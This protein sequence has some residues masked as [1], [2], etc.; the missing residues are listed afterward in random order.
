MIKRIITRIAPSPTGIAHLGSFRT[1]LFNYLFAKQHNGKF[2]LRIE[3]TDQERFVPEAE[4]YIIESLNWLGIVPDEGVNADGTATY[5]QSERKEIYKQHLQVLLDN[6]SAYYAFDTPAELEKMRMDFGNPKTK[7]AK[8]DSVTRQYMK[9]SL[10]LSEAEVKELVATG[11]YVV[12]FRNE[13]NQL[14][15]FKD[16]I[17]GEIT[18]NT[19]DLD[20]KV[21][22]KGKQ[23]LPTYHL[24]NVVDDHLMEV[25]HV[26]RGEEWISSTPLHILLYNAFGWDFPDFYHLPLILRP[27]GNGKLSKRDGDLMGF[28]VHPLGYRQ[29]GFEPQA[30]VNFLA[31]LGWNPGTEQEIYSMDE[32]VRDFDIHRVQR[33]GAKFDYEKA[34]WFNQKHVAKGVNLEQLKD[35]EGNNLYPKYSKEYIEQVFNLVKDRMTFASDFWKFSCYFFMSNPLF[36]LL[37]NIDENGNPI[38]ESKMKWLEKFNPK[39]RAFFNDYSIAI[40]ETEDFTAE[41]LHK[42]AVGIC[43]FLKIK[44]SDVFPLFRIALSGGVPGASVF[45]IQAVLGKEAS[46]SRIREFNN[47][48]S[49]LP[50]S[51]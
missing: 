24:A 28:P 50:I 45:D 35:N 17:R 20:D 6:G 32:L 26:I 44:T 2:L 13:I 3:D 21:I 49:F 40:Q 19:S 8:Y 48:T 22:F 14:V 12:R 36:M 30:V 39:A 37:E 10:T 5:R 7:D 11:D 38:D 31:F 43:E 9:N 29:Q 47:S 34:K 4:K 46:I 33:A 42:I 16:Q 1:A 15:T 51:V 25:T 23:Q 41:N 27:K 18:F